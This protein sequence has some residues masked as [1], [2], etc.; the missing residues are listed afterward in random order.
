[1][2]LSEELKMDFPVMPPQDKLPDSFVEDML[3]KASVEGQAGET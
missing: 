1:M 3:K 2:K